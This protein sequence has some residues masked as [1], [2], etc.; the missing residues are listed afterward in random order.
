MYR[1][2]MAAFD[3]PISSITAGSGTRSS[4]DRGR[5]VPGVVQPGVS[6]L[7]QPEQC[8]PRAVIL[9]RVH[10]PSEQV[11]EDPASVLPQVPGLLT[12]DRLVCPVRL[13]CVDHLVR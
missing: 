3:Q 5:R 9:G 13:Q 6:H 7:S 11:G 1:L 4:Q 10:R 8:L 12:V 2:A